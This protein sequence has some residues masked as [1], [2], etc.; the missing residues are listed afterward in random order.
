MPSTAET[1]PILYQIDELI[2]EHPYLHVDENETN[3]IRGSLEF[4]RSFEGISIKDKFEIEIYLPKNFPDDLPL[5]KEIGGRIPSD[6]HKNPD[7]TFCFGAPEEVKRIFR[8][9]PT[10]IGFVRNLVEPYLYS[11]IYKEKYGKMPWGELSHGEQGILEHYKERFGVSHDIA[12]I[13]L[14]RILADEDDRGHYDCPCG[15][16][17]RLRD[18]HRE[19]LAEVRRNQKTLDF[20]NEYINI[21]LPKLLNIRLND[22]S[23]NKDL[24]KREVV[25]LSKI[26]SELDKNIKNNK[27]KEIYFQFV[28]YLRKMGHTVPGEYISKTLMRNMKKSKGKH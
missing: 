24:D 21:V 15:S 19:L 6:F 8:A 16:G 26:L 5:A 9:C 20:L 18:C 23:V 7:E 22:N 14:L 25:R 17:K 27:T 4:N 11:F 10:L 3:T 13:G 1:L 12:A 2:R 28:H